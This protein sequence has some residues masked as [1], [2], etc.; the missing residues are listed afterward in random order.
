MTI[1]G[2]VAHTVRMATASLTLMDQD[3]YVEA[4]PLV[5]VAYEH[6]ILAQRV[7]ADSH[8]LDAF[9]TLTARDSKRYYNA[10]EPLANIPDDL[11]VEFE[12]LAV[13]T[14]KAK[15]VAKFADVCND[16]DST[17]W[18]YL[19]YKA[20]SRPV[21]PSA[22]AATEYVAEHDN[23]S[24]Y[25]LLTNP[26]AEDHRLVLFPLALAVAVA[27]GVYEDVRRG[28]PN[29]ARVRDAA[30]RAGVPSMLKLGAAARQAP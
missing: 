24:G 30:A 21:H 28:K 15:A 26:T 29:K 7:N 14:A 23:P 16:F 2:L 19:I 17:G 8:G 12:G 9:H 6:A 11:R 18:L 5:R 3:L 13:D 10:V 1:H 4:T 27:V 25:A 22:T 20:L